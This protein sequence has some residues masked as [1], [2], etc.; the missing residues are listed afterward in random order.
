[1]DGGFDFFSSQDNSKGGGFSG[2]SDFFDAF[3]G[4]RGKA[5]TQKTDGANVTYTLNVPF[6]DAALGSVKEISLANG[7]KIKVK[8]PAGTDNNSTLRLKGEGMAGVGGGKTG[9]AMITVKVT[10]HPVFERV[11][12]DISVKLS[13]TLKEAV[14]GAKL[15]VPTL[16]GTA[17]V[18]IPPNTSNT[19]L[20]LRGKGV[21][22]SSGT[23]DLLVK[24]NIVLPSGYDGEL[25]KF[26]KNWKGADYLVRR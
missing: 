6:V 19:I 4:S 25:E 21:K 26:V 3:K 1:M 14:L 7:K 15:P 9:D 24:V 18:K 23:G 13:I 17:M 10:P 22:T 5:R 11:G 20:R 12:N 8:I 2:W 16:D